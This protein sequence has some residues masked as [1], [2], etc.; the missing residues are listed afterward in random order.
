MAD[1]PQHGAF[2]LLKSTGL[3]KWSRHAAGPQKKTTGQSVNNA[4]QN[5]YE[6][7]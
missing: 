4:Y 2:V 6:I 5:C 7:I 3:N 1:K